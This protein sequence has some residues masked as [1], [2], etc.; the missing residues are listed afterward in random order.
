MYVHL[1]KLEAEFATRGGRDRTYFAL[2]VQQF[3]SSSASGMSNGIVFALFII[4]HVVER[5]RRRRP[6][7]WRR[8]VGQQRGG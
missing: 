7:C 8:H 6:V 2:S 1:R 4:T 3:H 5:S